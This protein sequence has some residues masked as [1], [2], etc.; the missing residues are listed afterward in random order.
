MTR[1]ILAIIVAIVL[2]AL[3]T[4]GVILYA[5]KADDRAQQRLTDAI[6]VVVAQRRIPAGTSGERIRS[7][8]LIKIERMPRT[9][10][11]T[12][13][14]SSVG[15]DLD[16]LVL[17]SAVAPGQLLMTAMFDDQN[18][19]NS[20]LTLP[21]GKMAVTVETGAPEQVAGYVQ[22][23]SKVAIFLTYTLLDAKG[24]ETQFKRTRIL[25]PSVEVMAIGTYKAESPSNGNGSTATTATARTGGSAMVTLAVNQEEGERLI[26]GLNTG[27][28]YI[29]LL[30]DSIVVKPGSG[31]DN[32]DA[33]GGVKPLF[34]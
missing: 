7:E 2:A 22:P 32:K 34:P 15:T 1:R 29:G 20:G 28:L 17:T 19:V 27:N 30:T 16:K 6:D 14:L 23:G 12:D 31:V 4:G 18:T 11:P 5:V 33:S 13:V 3:G 9:S 10:V 26:E 24:E 21:K 8:D 25:L